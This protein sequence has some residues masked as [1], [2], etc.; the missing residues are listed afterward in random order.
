MQNHRFLTQKH[1]LVFILFLL[2]VD[3]GDLRFG[4]DPTRFRHVERPLQVRLVEKRLLKSECE[5]V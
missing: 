5:D 3:V 2:A 1:A 4:S